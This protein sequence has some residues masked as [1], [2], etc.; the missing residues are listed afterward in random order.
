[1]KRTI[2]TIILVAIAN[3]CMFAQ[4]NIQFMDIP[5]NGDF[6]SFKEKLEMK[7]IHKGSLGKN[8]FSGFFFGKIASISIGNN[9]E[10]DNVYSALVRYNQ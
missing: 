10:T 4:S 8:V 5:L 1:M 2:L 7:D 3:I 6:D 9:D